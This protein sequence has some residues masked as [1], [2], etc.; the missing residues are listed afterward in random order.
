MKKR[1][2]LG[3]IIYKFLI[4]TSIS[5]NY[6]VKK[7][8]HT[9][10]RILLSKYNGSAK[11]RIH[12]KSALVNIGYTYPIYIKKFPFLN[13]PLIELV[14]QTFKYKNR[15]IN[16]I[17]IGAAVGDTA[18]LINDKCNNT[19]EHLYCIDGDEEFSQYLTENLKQLS[20]AKAIIA[21]L[22]SNGIETK[23][24]IRTHSGTAS[25][26]GLS[27]SKSTSLDDLIIPLDLSHID[28]IKIDVIVIGIESHN[29]FQF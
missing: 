17:D 29:G 22:S 12:G 13:S 20:Y 21:V 24:L 7:Y 28:I 10:W 3:E 14:H 5:Q 9:I 4:Y 2:I 8:W 11:I 18:L 19:V 26:Q 15:K 23:S 6:F 25:A 16:V 27:T 1:N